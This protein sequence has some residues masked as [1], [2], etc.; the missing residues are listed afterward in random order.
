MG[1]ILCSENSP[2][3]IELLKLEESGIK[4]AEY[5]T[6]LPPK[7]LLEKK[8]HTAIEMAKTQIESRSN[9]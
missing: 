9:E 6:E 5:M 1:L 4:V 2:E 3:Q 7:K 8:L